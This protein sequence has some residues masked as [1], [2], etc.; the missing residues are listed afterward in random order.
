[1]DGP[2]KYNISKVIQKSRKEAE[3]VEMAKEEGQEVNK[4]TLDEKVEKRPGRGVKG[5]HQ[6]AGSK[7]D[8]GGNSTTTCFI[9]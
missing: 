7:G 9:L 5:R 8:E 3:R 2:W 1:M 6:G 4:R